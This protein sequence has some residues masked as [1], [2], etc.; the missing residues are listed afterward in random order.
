MSNRPYTN[1]IKWTH[2]PASGAPRE[3][4]ISTA[5]LP[6]ETPAQTQARHDDAVEFF[7]IHYPPDPT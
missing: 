6:G 1:P 7:Q 4:E 2:T 5:A 3:I